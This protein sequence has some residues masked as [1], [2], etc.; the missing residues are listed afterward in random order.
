VA[1]VVAALYAGRSSAFVQDLV[2][3]VR[4][5]FYAVLPASAARELQARQDALGA[6][7][8][9]VLFIGN[10]LTS[11][12]DVPAM[13][14]RLATAANESRRFTSGQ[15]TA[16]GFKL[17]QHLAGGRIAS[18]LGEGPWDA[19][20]LQEQG[21]LPGWS[22]HREAEF[23]APARSLA[24]AISTTHARVVLYDTPARRQGDPGNYPGDTYDAMQ[25]R[26][27]RGYAARQ[28]VARTGRP[29]G[30]RVPRARAEAARARAVGERRPPSVDRGNLPRGL[31]VLRALL[32][33]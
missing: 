28:R 21:Q 27:D 17:S 1:L 4:E 31:L 18:R 33:A 23:F 8:L 9:R 32:S 6:V 25:E 24:S 19:V 26:I 30:H 15:E 5:A 14:S 29:G 12:N 7:P 22:E 3:S 11:T 16:G 10:S 20:V 13:I 2:D